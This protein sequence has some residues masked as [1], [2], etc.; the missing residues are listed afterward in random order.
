M[1]GDTAP[2]PTSSRDLAA[3]ELGIF[4]FQK[5]LQSDSKIFIPRACRKRIL[6]RLQLL[7]KASAERLVDQ[8]LCSTKST[9]WSSG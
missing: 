2:P 5:R 6:F 9:S 1:T 4:L 3:F 7:R 8:A